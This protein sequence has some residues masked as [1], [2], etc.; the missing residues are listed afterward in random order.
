MAWALQP[1]VAFNIAL[2]GRILLK[3][4][5]FTIESMTAE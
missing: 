4:K 1:Y 3:S 2:Y 5:P